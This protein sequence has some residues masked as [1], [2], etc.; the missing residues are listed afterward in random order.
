M[1]SVNN[2]LFSSGRLFAILPDRKLT[3]AAELTELQREYAAV[4]F[5][6]HVSNFNKII[7]KKQIFLFF[8]FI[9]YSVNNLVGF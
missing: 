9:F 2:F 8:L 4:C 3:I 5:F 1:D 6:S 7:E